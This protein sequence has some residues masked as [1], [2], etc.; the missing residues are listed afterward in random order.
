MTPA[1]PVRLQLALA[2]AGVAS[3]RAAE[4]LILAGR[5]TVNGK[6][7]TMLGT[8]VSVP[9][10]RLTVDGR[11]VAAVGRQQVYLFNKPRGV[12]S[13]MKRDKEE[14]TC[15]AEVITL[16]ERVFIVGRLDADSE[17]LLILTND[18]ELAQRLS[19][20][21]YEHEKEYYVHCR[22]RL[23]EADLRRLAQ[24]FNIEGYRTKPATVRQKSARVFS[25]IL[26]EGRNRQIRRMCQQVGLTVERLVRVRVGQYWLGT[27]QPGKIQLASTV[28]R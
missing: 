11:A 19:H 27:L 16:P 9:P 13:T 26:R 6:V 5:V 10:D 17:G 7:V 15:V 3:R 12:I 25:I 2:R 18:G 23:T 8:K 14:G 20:P 24:P 21:R 4:E 28:S 22:E 1:A